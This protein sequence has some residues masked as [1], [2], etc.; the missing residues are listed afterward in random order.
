MNK[1]TCHP[2]KEAKDGMSTLSC[3]QLLLPTPLVWFLCLSC[4]LQILTVTQM[5]NV[6]GLI[7]TKLPRAHS[8]TIDEKNHD[9]SFWGIVST[10]DVTLHLECGTWWVIIRHW[11]R[12]QFTCNSWA[13]DSSD[14]ICVWRWSDCVNISPIVTMLGTKQKK[15]AS[16]DSAVLT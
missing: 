3:S 7:G 10:G 11:K 2:T 12:N 8:I 5:N 16:S 9:C 6:E 1:L 13:I 4:Q 14:C 15:W